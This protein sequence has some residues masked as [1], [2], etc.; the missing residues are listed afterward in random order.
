MSCGGNDGSITVIPTEGN[1][2]YSYVWSNGATSNTISNLTMGEYTVTVSGTAG[3][4]IIKTFKLTENTPLTS[5]NIN[6]LSQ[7]KF[8]TQTNYEGQAKAVPVGGKLP[9]NYKWNNGQTTQTAINLKGN[10]KYY[11][12]VKDACNITK[13]SFILMPYSDVPGVTIQKT[14][15]TCNGDATGKATAIPTGV[16][17]FRYKWS[18]GKTTQTISNLP[19]STYSVTVTDKGC[20]NATATAIT[21]ITQPQPF[22]LTAIAYPSSTCKNTGVAIALPKYGTP[23]YAYKWSN[24]ATTDTIT[25]LA[26]GNYTVTVKDNC[27]TSKSYTVYVGQKTIFVTPEIINCTM[28]NQCTGTLKVKVN[29]GDPPYTYLWNNGQTQQQINSVC[30]G[31]YSVTVTD[32]NGCTVTKDNIY[33]PLCTAKQYVI[34][35]ENNFIDYE[36][37]KLSDL[38][39]INIYPNP[40]K[41]FLKIKIENT[42]ELNVKNGSLYLCS[43]DGKIIINESFIVNEYVNLDV[44]DLKNGLYIL[45]II[46]DDNIFNFKVSV[47]NN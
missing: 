19:A 7:D 41:Y 25:K 37:K 33:M 40:V 34:S 39:K 43:L 22:S 47:Y 17:S 27:N 9:Y 44:S 14:D 29:G 15:V 45:K 16:G 8:C 35:P 20:N 6:I 30:E 32:Y 28:P 21:T 12:T 3:C 23:P 1:E 36:N 31:V 4:K 5:V 38:I 13:T 46:I 24:G 18:N 26:S 10:T 2:P 11:V 42:G